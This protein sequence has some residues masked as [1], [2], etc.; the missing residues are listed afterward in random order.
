MPAT[1]Y[2]CGARD[3]HGS[4]GHPCGRAADSLRNAG[5]E[6]TVETVD[7]YRL[8]PWTRRGDVRTK[9]REL[10][11]QDN[12]P[13]LVLENGEVVTGSGQIA[14]WAKVQHEA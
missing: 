1:L 14:K 4:M 9:V 10:S 11:G 5:V 13:I 6:F 3:K 7:G 8:L 12:V 2:T